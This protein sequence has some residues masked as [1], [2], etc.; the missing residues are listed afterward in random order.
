MIDGTK[1]VHSPEVL[2][3]IF[4]LLSK[5]DHFGFDFLAGLKS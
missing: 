4:I 1:H 2:T 5:G 3:L